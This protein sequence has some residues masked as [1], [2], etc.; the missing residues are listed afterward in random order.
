VAVLEPWPNRGRG[1]PQCLAQVQYIHIEGC[2]TSRGRTPIPQTR[3]LELQVHK[4]LRISNLIRVFADSD[5]SITAMPSIPVKP[6]LDGVRL[7]TPEDLARIAT[8]AA[9]GFFHSPTF[10]YQR[11]YHAAYPDD[12]LL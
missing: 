3:A 5:R 6:A 4:L 9:A 7:A 10:H 2:T 8:V 1:N 12:T 11:I